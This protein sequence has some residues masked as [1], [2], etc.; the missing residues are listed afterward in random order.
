MPEVLL[1]LPFCVAFNFVP[2]E[3]LNVRVT[4]DH[5]Y[6]GQKYRTAT[7]D[8]KGSLLS[9]ESDESCLISEPKKLE[10]EMVGESFRSW[11]EVKKLD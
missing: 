7:A 9:Q 8:I 11:P 1:L 10:G 4:S 5:R 3:H 2:R 6:N